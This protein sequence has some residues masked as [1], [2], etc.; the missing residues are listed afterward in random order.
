MFNINF[1]KMKNLNFKTVAMA[2]IAVFSLSSCQNDDTTDLVQEQPKEVQLPANINIVSAEEVP[3][4]VMLFSRSASLQNININ[5]LKNVTFKGRLSDVQ[6]NNKQKDD[7]EPIYVDVNAHDDYTFDFYMKPFKV[8]K[9]PGYLRVD[10][11]NIPLN[12]DGSFS[13][14]INNDRELLKDKLHIK[15]RKSG[16]PR[17]GGWDYDVTLIEGKF[18]KVSGGYKIHLTLESRGTIIG[19]EIFKAHVVYDG[20]KL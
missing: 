13:A 6:M 11:Q 2:A 16:D 18:T 19:I 17:E 8:G 10:I 4:D 5:E 1:L 12:K 15:F 7:V 3:Q 20:D 9:M 14:D